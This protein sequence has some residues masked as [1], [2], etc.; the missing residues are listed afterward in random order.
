MFK[1]IELKSINSKII[2]LVII[3]IGVLLIIFARGGNTTVD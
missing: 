3:S 1:K 2:A